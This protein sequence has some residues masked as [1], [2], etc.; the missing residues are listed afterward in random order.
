VKLVVDNGK[1]KG[2]SM[3]DKVKSTISGNKEVTV[4]MSRQEAFRIIVNH[5]W[6]DSSWLSR[7]PCASLADFGDDVS[8]IF[9]EE[10]DERQ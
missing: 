7:F 1:V 10:K 9:K 4:T 5:L 6:A 3:G 2:P 8:I